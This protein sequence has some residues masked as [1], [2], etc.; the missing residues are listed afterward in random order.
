MREERMQ[1]LRMVEKG[2]ISAAEGVQLLE[3]LADEDKTNDGETISADISSLGDPRRFWVYPAL[4]GAGIAA[5]G[6]ALYLAIY[7]RWG[8]TLWLTCGIVP[9]LT[10]VTIATLGWW[11]RQARWFHL[12]ITNLHTD[13]RQFVMSLPLPLRLTAWVVSIARPF[14]PRFRDTGLDEMILSLR[15]GIEQS[16]QPLVVDVTDEDEGERIQIYFG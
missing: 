11:S 15:D 6:A 1:I 2:Q 9:F 16:G 7:A 12:R 13:Q 14:I 4:A 3:A 8:M 5:I 10:G